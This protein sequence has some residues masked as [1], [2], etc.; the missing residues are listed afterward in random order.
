MESVTGDLQ[1]NE[2]PR[3][4]CCARGTILGATAKF[5]DVVRPCP[6]VYN[7]GFCYSSSV[8]VNLLRC[9]VIFV[10]ILITVTFIHEDNN[11]NTWFVFSKNCR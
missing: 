6:I 5:E 4:K 2:L 10:C 1:L 3:K 7:Y 11:D 8:S 9:S